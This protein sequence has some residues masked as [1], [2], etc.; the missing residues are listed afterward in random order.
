[1]SGILVAAEC[2]DGELRGGSR[3]AIA[4]AVRLREDGERVL[5][6][7]F[8]ASPEALRQASVDGVDEILK[9]QIPGQAD[10]QEFEGALE[11]V[12]AA[13]RPWLVLVGQSVN[14]LGYVP[15]VAARGGYGFASD[16]TAISRS[17]QLAARR[18][19]F[20]GKLSVELAFTNM[21]VTLLMLREGA[22]QPGDDPA[23]TLS[24]REIPLER[25]DRKTEHLGLE[26]ASVD[27]EAAIE[28]AEF[29]IAV[30]RGIEDEDDL[31]QFSVLADRIGAELCGSRP[32][33]DAGLIPAARQ[34]GQSGR[35]VEPKVYL[36]FGI[37]GAVQHLA[38]IAKAKLI[39]AVNADAAAPI[40]QAANYG[41]V[42]DM[43]DVA[44]E[45]GRILP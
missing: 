32:L 29:L 26:V 11:Q 21:A 35:S 12:I 27:Q 7:I 45:L 23:T 2:V 4:T 16:V 17:P 28:D 30:G 33:V 9:V 42:A 3:E 6:S 19:A 8:G 10:S 34:V 18:P 37:S 38:G 25:V 44:A 1:M 43:Y 22:F 39:I 13:E 36:A 24:S 5:V 41:A 15:A 14:A 40:F 31:Q 20:G